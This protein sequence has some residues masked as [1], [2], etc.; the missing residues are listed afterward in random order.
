M[1]VSR[2]T[3]RVMML[4]SANFTLSCTTRPRI[5]ALRRRRPTRSGRAR[6]GVAIRDQ[7]GL[8]RTCLPHQR[9]SLHDQARP[10]VDRGRGRDPEVPPL[11]AEA[12]FQPSN[13]HVAT[14]PIVFSP[15]AFELRASFSDLRPTGAS[16]V[17]QPGKP[18]SP[19]RVFRAGHW[20]ARSEAILATNFTGAMQQRPAGIVQQQYPLGRVE[21]CLQAR[22][23]GPPRR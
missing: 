22:R 15:G 2:V 4:K 12:L 17:K 9:S 5:P 8:P 23:T 7:S 13:V 19:Q 16:E 11:R 1:G 6:A 18:R 3:R 10:R 21:R 14:S 20:V